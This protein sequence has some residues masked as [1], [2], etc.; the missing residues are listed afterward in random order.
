LKNAVETNPRFDND[1]RTSKCR[2]ENRDESDKE[3]DEGVNGRRTEVGIW[4]EIM[5]R[6]A[7]LRSQPRW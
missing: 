3:N 4:F 7:A 2:K 6:K 5:R 1:L